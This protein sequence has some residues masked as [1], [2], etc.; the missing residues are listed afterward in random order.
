MT[1]GA[2]PRR[3]TRRGGRRGMGVIGAVVLVCLGWLPGCGLTSNGGGPFA[4]TAEFANGT[5]LYPGSPVRVLGINVGRV[6]NVT[7]R[8][9][10]VFVRMSLHR[11]VALP[12]Q[13]YATIVPLTLLGERY[14]QLGPA[15]THGPRLASGAAI[16]MTRTAVPAEFD[17]LLRGLQ[18]FTGAIDP[19]RAS[20]VVTDLATVLQGRGARLNDL[21]GNAS[22]TLQLLANKGEDLHRII[23]SLADLNEA[24]RGRT[25][26]IETLIQNYDLVAEVL[27]ANKNDLDATIT[28]FD[29]ATRELASFLA[30]HRAPLRTDIGVLTRTVQTVTANSDN[31]K[32]TLR[33]TVRLFEAAGRAYNRRMNALM[34][35][36][37][38]APDVTSAMVAGRLRDRIAGLCRR[39]KVAACSDPASPLLNGL[40][41]TLP[42]II[43][44]LSSGGAGSSP[45][46]PTSPPPTPAA[47][48]TSPSAPP[49][50]DQLVSLLAAQLTD[51]LSPVQSAALGG[52]DL[53]KLTTLL[54]LDPTLLQVL[55]KLDA[56]QLQL[57]HDAKAADLPNVLLVLS[58]ELIPP[59]SRLGPLLPGTSGSAPQAPAPS[60][61]QNPLSQLF[62][63]MVGGL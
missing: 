37:Q 10:H 47:P 28:E 49:S 24:L 31:L 40:A 16:P 4:V 1:A 39:L 55:P 43:G 19:H 8:G 25:D 54:S 17:D 48:T 15:Y 53:Q 20:S 63:D 11:G 18:D 35:N 5:G 29:R 23:A 52:L 34:A 13:A 33:S 56:G 27:V 3:P 6:A 42:G 14:V 50:S 38:L 32:L 22:T 51:R 61:S 45:S 7:N 44:Q 59:A 30:E 21:I 46:I 12:A 41:S 36:N 26:R 57:L 58:N 60:G 2:A 9:G 62:G